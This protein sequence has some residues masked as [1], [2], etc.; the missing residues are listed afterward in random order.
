MAKIQVEFQYFK[1]SGKWYASETIYMELPTFRIAPDDPATEM[2]DHNVLVK[3]IR[4]MRARGK[5]PG[6]VD[7]TPDKDEFLWIVVPIFK[8][9]RDFGC[10]FQPEWLQDKVLDEL[11]MHCRTGEEQMNKKDAEEEVVAMQNGHTW[12]KKEENRT[13]CSLCGKPV[14]S[15]DGFVLRGESKFHSVCFYDDVEEKCKDTRRKLQDCRTVLRDL[16]A[17]RDRPINAFPGTLQRIELA[18]IDSEPGPEIERK[19]DY[20]EGLVRSFAMS[21]LSS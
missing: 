13:I 14:E 6:L 11:G 5:R 21:L 2:V 17:H 10:A 4:D 1:L 16:V 7:A 20:A 9:E 18:L 19:G 8:G 12:S 15:K 3:Q